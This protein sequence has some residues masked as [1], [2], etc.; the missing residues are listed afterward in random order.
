MKKLI[1]ILFGFISIASFSQVSS[2]DSLSIGGTTYIDSVFIRNDSLLFRI[3]RTAREY[4]IA[5]Y[6]TGGGEPP[7]APPSGH[8]VSSSLGDD[9]TGNGSQEFPWETLAYAHSQATSPGD[10]ILLMRGDVFPSTSVL[11]IT[12][13]GSSGNPIVWNGSAWGSGLDAIIQKSQYVASAVRIV[14]CDYVI[15]ENITID[16]QNYNGSGII[17]GGYQAVYGAPQQANE[18]SIILQDCKVMDIGTDGWQVG[19]GVIAVVDTQ[20]YII[21]RRDSVDGST[22]HGIAYYPHRVSIG[23]TAG[24]GT[25]YS[26]I[27]YNV[28]TNCGQLLNGVA[29][30][31]MITQNQDSAICEH[32]VISSSSSAFPGIAMGHDQADPTAIPKDCIVRYNDVRMTGNPAFQIQLGGD[33]DIDIYYNIFSSVGQSN[34]RTVYIQSA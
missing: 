12:N 23:G 2:P 7:A 6:T 19:I 13:G 15:F 25:V 27:G 11:N 14:A 24:A 26:Y 8:Y 33:I 21:V 1:L 20:S 18:D 16:G 29:S 4:G 32:N 5:R 28:I 30:G 17:V 10:S 34:G 22:N 3:E 9:V 31:I